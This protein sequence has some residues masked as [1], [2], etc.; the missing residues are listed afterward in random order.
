MTQKAAYN[1]VVK[2]STFPCTGSM[3]LLGFD[4]I[5]NLRE[6]MT[7]KEGSNFNM[8][9]FHNSLLSFGSVPVSM[10]RREMVGS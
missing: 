10:I 9:R 7:L 1:E 2:N 8:Q 3:Y 5:M 6:E 4:G